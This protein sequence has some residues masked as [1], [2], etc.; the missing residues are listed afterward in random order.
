MKT[1]A[2]PDERLKVH[3]LHW[4]EEDKPVVRRLPQRLK[5]TFREVVWTLAQSPAGGRIRFATDSL[6][7]GVR[8]TVPDNDV[9]HHIT[10][11]GQSGFD[12]YVDGYFAGSVSPNAQGKISNDWNWTVG[13]DKQFRNIEISMPLYK[14]VTIESIVLDDDAIIKEPRPYRISRPIV[15]Y[16]TSITQ[17]GCA[18]TPGT[19]YQSFISR[20][21]D[22]DFVNLGFSGNG[23]GEPELAAAISEIDASCFVVDFWA[24]VGGDDYGKKLP[25]FVGPIRENYPETPIVVVQP[26]FFASDRLDCSRH[27][28]MRRDSEAFVKRLSEQGDKNIHLLDGYKMISKE[29]TFGLVDGVHPNSLGFYFMAK[30][31]APL[32][33]SVL[34]L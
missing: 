21:L 6:V 20:W 27:E 3:G 16:G 34:G 5:G 24:N 12:I 33:K 2:F 31:M 17:G 28:T 26:F 1:I 9:M 13:T 22:A 14:P 7:I 32:L 25:G 4:F 8:A 30:G 10:K 29:E 19:S 18:S 15:Y 11:I 23:F